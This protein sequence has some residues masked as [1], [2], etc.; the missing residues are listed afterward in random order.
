[1]ETD[2]ATKTIFADFFMKLVLEA[3]FITVTKE[4]MN[5]F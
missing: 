1:M 5:I 3:D 2:A 4:K